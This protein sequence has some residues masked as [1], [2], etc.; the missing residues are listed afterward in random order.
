MKINGRI[1]RRALWAVLFASF[2][3][4][5]GVL[6]AAYSR[7]YERG[8]N[9][10]TYDQIRSGMLLAEVTELL[11][12]PPAA[13]FVNAQGR[14]LAWVGDRISFAVNFDDDNRVL[15]KELH[16]DAGDRQSKL[17]RFLGW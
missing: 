8:L 10:E 12:Q 2:L 7:P 16:K 6:I 17:R 5:T 4:L 3:G 9:R 13:D 15:A 14:W 11:G 1:V